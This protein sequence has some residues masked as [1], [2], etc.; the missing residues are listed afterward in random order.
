MED[1][2]HEL[3]KRILR[4]VVQ[5]ALADIDHDKAIDEVAACIEEIIKEGQRK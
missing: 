3:S 1:K 2:S 4:V 5:L